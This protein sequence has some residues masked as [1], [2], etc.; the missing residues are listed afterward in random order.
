MLMTVFY[1][2]K[3]KINGLLIMVNRLNENDNVNF[4]DFIIIKHKNRI[5]Y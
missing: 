1:V 4:L 5:Y 2:Y 3:Q